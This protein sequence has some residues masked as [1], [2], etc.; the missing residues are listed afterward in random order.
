MDAVE[1]SASRQGKRCEFVL[2]LEEYAGKARVEFV[3]LLEEYACREGH[4]CREGPRDVVPRTRPL[5]RQGCS[6]HWRS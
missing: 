6:P 5:G 1:M 4:A 3:L 2:L